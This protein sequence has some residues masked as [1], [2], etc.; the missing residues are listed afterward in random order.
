M[1]IVQ[2]NR[3][4]ENLFAGWPG[5]DAPLVGYLHTGAKIRL[6]QMTYQDDCFR[7]QGIQQCDLG[8]LWHEAMLGWNHGKMNGFDLEG[9]GTLGF[10]P[11]AGTVPYA[12][13]DHSEIAPYRAMAKNYV[14]VDHMF[15]TEFGTSFTAHQDLI[16]GTTQIDRTHSLVDVPLPGPPWGCEAP[17]NTYTVLVNTQ[18]QLSNNGPYPCFT[19]YATMAD[20]LDAKHV[21]WKYYAPT[22]GVF[23]GQV[24]SA[25]TAIK[26][27]YHG[28]DRQK[29]VSPETRALTDPANGILPAVSWVIPDLNWSDHPI[30]QSNLGPQ[31]VG[32]VVNA[33]GKSKYWKSAAIVILWDDWGGYY[34]NAP[35]KQLDYVGLGIRVPCLIISPYAKRGYVSHTTYEF[36]SILKF[37]EDTFGLASLNTS[38]VRATSIEDSFDFGQAPRTF[39]PIP[40]KVPASYFI[41]QPQSIQAPDND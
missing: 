39:K 22:T 37:V 10:G 36:G 11:P 15:P 14:L 35:P 19:Q 34:D 26:N 30:V 29:I 27:V 33:I 40:T 7:V 8:H 25:F 6:H 21:S 2:E 13:L 38:D 20:T 9:T 41:S 28:P 24:W 5:A 17:Y 3:S 31:W 4:F 12:Y 16:A 32:D 18:R 1:I 23:A